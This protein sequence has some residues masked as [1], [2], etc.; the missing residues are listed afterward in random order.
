MAQDR[1]RIV[2]ATRNV[3]KIREIVELYSDLPIEWVPIDSLGVSPEIE[4]TGET[5]RDNAILKACG[6][7]RWS[8]FPTLA[9]D[10]GLIVDALDGAPGVRSARFAGEHAS[11]AD[12][13][14]LL[15]ERLSNVPDERRTA[16][17]HASLIVWWSESEYDEADGVC[18]GR[19]ARAPSGNTG[20]GYDPVFVPDG[21][22]R[23]FAVLGPDVKNRLSHR[24][25]ALKRLRPMLE[26]R[27][28]V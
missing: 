21:Y 17:F 10:S 3:G 28:G 9:D 23:S 19:I 11:D 4:E 16:R 25:R 26:R 6:I 20:F 1:T 5:F 22:E 2:I 15:L 13:V 14:R 18:E 8:G 12:N 24:A 7:S 27:L